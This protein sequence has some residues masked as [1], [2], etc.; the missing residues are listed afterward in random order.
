MEKPRAVT[1][2]RCST[3]EEA[4]KDALTHQIM[5]AKN[6]ILEQGWQLVDT[7][8]E[9]KSGTTIKGRTEYNRLYKDLERDKFDIIVI[10]SQ[11]RLM[12]NTKDWYLF[13]DRMQRNGK[14]LYMYLEHKFYSPDDALVTGIKAILAEE[15][16]RELSKKINHA[17]KNRQKEGM[18]FVFT[19]RTY[20]LQKLPDKSIAVDRQE[21]EMVKMI[22][23]LSAN[24]YGTHCSAEIL[25]ENGYRNR[26]G[27]MLHPSSIRNIIR[28]PIYKGTVVQN[29]VHYD[30]DSKQVIKN[31]K[32][33]WVI[34]EKAIPAIVDEDLF[35]RA[36]KGLDARK[37]KKQ[38]EEGIKACNAGK[39]DFSGKIICGL[40]K[41]P[42]YR[43]SRK[44]KGD[45]V[46]EWKCCNYLRNGRKKEQLCKEKLRKTKKGDQGCDNIHLDERKIYMALEGACRE[47]GQGL[48]TQKEILLKKTL[49]IVREALRRED[50]RKENEEL[51]EALTKITG[52]KD[53][54]LEKLLE[55]T[56][57]DS[58]FRRK[59]RQI[60]DR[61]GQIHARLKQNKDEILQDAQIDGRVETIQER[62][63]SGMLEQAQTADMVGGIE[64]IEVFPDC[65]KIY[66]SSRHGKDWME[67]GIAPPGEDETDHQAV[68]VIPQTCSALQRTAM[69]EEKQAI[70]DYMKQKPAI[71]AKEIAKEMEVGISLV[72]RRIRDLKKEGRVRYSTP[73][74]KGK[75]IIVEEND[76]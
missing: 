20:G 57:S 23:E 14:R 22:F 36:N 50:G 1:Y 40:C 38:R 37:Q 34:H 8:V 39:Y 9:A 65:L 10:K 25:Y 13:L 61:E 18:H 27:K 52:Q 47:N 75:W 6:C 62:L 2:N 58:D 48:K 5:E 41:S 59:K 49:Q 7:Y 30:F 60:E 68:L 35:D 24:G 74:G 76:N 11:D 3:E 55:G 19:N 15:Y 54:L 51:E 73:N 56:I 70:Q 29:R 72:H 46:T 64:K 31:P 17:H 4:Q 69:E 63:E 53:L 26:K 66:F 42:F 28:N 67:E 32:Q 45:R 44:G 33:E 43:V 16:S 21:A 12:R 71:T